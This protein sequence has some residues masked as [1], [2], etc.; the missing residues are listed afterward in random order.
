MLPKIQLLFLLLLVVKDAV[1]VH[2]SRYNFI[3]NNVTCVSFTNIIKHL[4]CEASKVATNTYAYSGKIVFNKSINKN[5]SLRYL[6]DITTISKSKLLHFIDVKMN[7]C[8]AIKVRYDIPLLQKLVIEIRRTS[9]FPYQ[10]PLQ[11]NF[12]Y[13]FKNLTFSDEF[14]NKFLPY[15]HFVQHLNLYESDKIIAGLTTKGS[16]LPKTKTKINIK[17]LL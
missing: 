11:P 15:F 9:N 4:E 14:L 7:I 8:D 13:T 5:Y 12:S 2:S 1:L 10:C 17:K 3:I 16:L 6:F